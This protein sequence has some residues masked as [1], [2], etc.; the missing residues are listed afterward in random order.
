MRTLA[1]HFTTIRVLG[2]GGFGI[3]KLVKSRRDG[4]LFAIKHFKKTP[5]M[6]VA[7]QLAEKEIALLKT[8][9]HPNIV[10]FHGMGLD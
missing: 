10:G 2:E 9:A 4:Q 6:A 7:M 8:L 3:V 5:N 1:E